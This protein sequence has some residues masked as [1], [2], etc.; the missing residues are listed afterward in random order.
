MSRLGEPNQPQLAAITKA[1]TWSP[2]DEE[3]ST[4]SLVLL[5]VVAD[6]HCKDWRCWCSPHLPNHQLLQTICFNTFNESLTRRP[7]HFFE[8]IEPIVWHIQ[9]LTRHTKP[10]PARVK[11][12]ST[13]VSFLVSPRKPYVRAQWR[14]CTTRLH[15]LE[16]HESASRA[17][18]RFY[19]SNVLVWDIKSGRSSCAASLWVEDGSKLQLGKL[20]EGGQ[21]L[22]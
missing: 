21:S 14:R 8:P 2:F 18:V 6:S 10:A 5:R 22:L 19:F 13:L 16:I 15:C 17:Q 12:F 1:V 3:L 20:P 11:V 7:N 9:Q 4:A